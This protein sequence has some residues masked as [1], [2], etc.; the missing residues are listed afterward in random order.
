VEGTK[1]DDVM[2]QI[3]LGTAAP[4]SQLGWPLVLNSKPA[5]IF[6]CVCE[7]STMRQQAAFSL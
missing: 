3:S 4:A 7:P 1:V 6:I 5:P 2:M